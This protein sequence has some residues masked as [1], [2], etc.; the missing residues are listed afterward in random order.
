LDLQPALDLELTT[1]LQALGAAVLRF[2]SFASRG[3]LPQMHIQ[4]PHLIE[5]ALLMPLQNTGA[6]DHAAGW[7]RVKLK[8]SS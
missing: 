8:E 6:D 3:S 4:N 5:L 7:A 1:A 2:E